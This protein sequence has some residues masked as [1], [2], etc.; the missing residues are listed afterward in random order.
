MDWKKYIL[1]FLITGIIFATAIYTS[2]YLNQKKMD[3]IRNIGD[4]ISVDIMSSET[5]YDLLAQSSCKGIENSVL[6]KE[7][8]SLGERLSY[9]QNERGADDPEVINLKK[10]YSLLQI[11]DYLLYQKISDKCNISPVFITYFYSTKEDCPDCEKQSYV[12]TSL[13]EKYPGLRVYSFD[14]NLD[15]TAIKTMISIYKIEDK[16]PVLIINDNVYNGFQ[17]IED[18]EKSAPELK[19]LEKSNASSTKPRISN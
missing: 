15:L 3:E 7:I 2:N 10:Y 8:N 5:Q 6:S 19:K 12:L 16:F 17:T 4:K 14:Y 1:A 18:I 11:K 13:H 9:I